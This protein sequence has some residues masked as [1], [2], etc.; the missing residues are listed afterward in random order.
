[1]DHR[2]AFDCVNHLKLWNMLN[3]NVNYMR[4]VES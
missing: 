4:N 3:G 2:K 1:M